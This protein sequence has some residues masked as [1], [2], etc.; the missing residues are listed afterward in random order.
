MSIQVSLLPQHFSC[1]VTVGSTL[2]AARYLGIPEDTSKLPLSGGIL[3]GPLNIDPTPTRVFSRIFQYEYDRTIA[4]SAL[5]TS[6]DGSVILIT[7]NSNQSFISTDYGQTFTYLT[8]PMIASPSGASM[9]SDGGVI[10]LIYPE[11]ARIFYSTNYGSTWSDSGVPEYY[12]SVSVSPDGSKIVG[13]TTSFAIGFNSSNGT[14]IFYHLG[15]YNISNIKWEQRVLSGLTQDVLILSNGGSLYI[16]VPPNLGTQ[17]DL[18]AD[19]ISYL[20]DF[21]TSNNGSVRL[22]WDPVSGGP[23]QISKDS[24]VTWSSLSGDPTK[25]WKKAVVSSTGKFQIAVQSNGDAYYSND[26]GDSWDS[27]GTTKNWIDINTTSDGKKSFFLA[28]D[29]VAGV[30]DGLFLSE[31]NVP[32]GVTT[33]AIS[34]TEFYNLPKASNT[35]YGV[36]KVDNN[37]VC[38]INGCLVGTPSFSLPTASSSTLGGVKVGTSLC[39]N[40][41]VL[42]SRVA[43]SSQLGS[44]KVGTSL[45]INNSIIDS[46]VASSSQLGAVKVGTSLCINNSVLDSRVAST[47]QLGAV[48][49]GN[50]L[51][52]DG[53]GFLSVAST[54]LSAYTS[55][56]NM[57]GVAS[58]GTSLNFSRGDHT[59]PSDTR[60]LSISGGSVTGVLAASAASFAAPITGTFGYFSGTLTAARIVGDLAAATFP[61]ASTIVPGVVKVDGTSI[62]INNGVI[63]GAPTFSLPIA[64]ASILGGV[65]I[66]SN[67]YFSVGGDGSFGIATAGY[68]TPGL[69]SNS[70]KVKLDNI[71]F[72]LGNPLMN[73]TAT[74]GSSTSYTRADHVHPS[75]TSRLPCSGGTLTGHLQGT[76]A[77]FTGGIMSQTNFT[78]PSMALSNCL[79]VTNGVSAGSFSGNG[80]SLTNL[81]AI[82]NCN[83]YIGCQAGLSSSGSHNTYLG[84]K[85]GQTVTGWCNVFIGSGTGNG[86]VSGCSNIAIGASTSGSLTSG[87]GNISMGASTTPSNTTGRDNI[88]IGN[89]ASFNNVSGSCNVALGINSLSL[90]TGSFNMGIGNH[91]MSTKTSGDCN[92][93]IGSQSLS[94]I[95]GTG[96]IAIG[97]RAGCA[98]T[99]GNNNIY[100]GHSWT[101]SQPH[102]T[103]TPCDSVVI[104]TNGKTY[105]T[106]DCNNTISTSGALCIYNNIYAPFNSVVAN[107]LC[108]SGTING[109][110]LCANSINAGGI[111]SR[112]SV[113]ACFS[114]CSDK[115][116]TKLVE[117]NKLLGDISRGIGVLRPYPGK[118]RGTPTRIAPALGVPN[119]Y[120]FSDYSPAANNYAVRII[121]GPNSTA[122]GSVQTLSDTTNNEI[123]SII[124]SRRLYGSGMLSLAND[125][126]FTEYFTLQNHS[127]FAGQGPATEIGSVLGTNGTRTYNGMSYRTPFYI[128][129]AGQQTVSGYVDGSY[130]RFS[131]P[132]C[133]IRS[134]TFGVTNLQPIW[135]V[136]DTGN[137]AIRKLQGFSNSTLLITST[138]AGSPARVSN[139]NGISGVGSIVSPKVI[140]MSSGGGYIFVWT[141][142]NNGVNTYAIRQVSVETGEIFATG[143]PTFTNVKAMVCS[144]IYLFVLN[145]NAVEVVSLSSKA[146][147]FRIGNVSQAGNVEGY[148]EN[149]RFNNPTDMIIDGNFLVITDAG[150]ND[151]KYVDVNTF[152]VRSLIITSYSEFQNTLS[153]S[154]SAAIGSFDSFTYNP[155]ALFSCNVI[156]CCVNSTEITG[157]VI[158][159][160]SCVTA[161]VVT[162]SNSVWGACCIGTSGNMCIFGQGILGSI[163]S[164]GDIIANGDI[165]AFATSD[166]RLKQNI[167]NIPDSLNKVMSLNG[168]SFDWCENVSTYIGRDIGV[169][170]QEVEDVMP[171]V[172]STRTNGYKAVRYEKLIPLL[173][174][175]IKELKIEIDD[176]KNK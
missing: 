12:N 79:Q 90:N 82:A 30:E 161:P 168:V 110:V 106:I 32:V 20:G 26:F 59:H 104:G 169:L 63:S 138:L 51:S 75:D 44:V 78:A 133:I 22:V 96:N 10:A 105:L 157:N 69:M 134:N 172:I 95:S 102:G 160:N 83:T 23:L 43:S 121:G 174:E 35:T 175:A 27:V 149:A 71:G 6:A 61:V 125:N 60:K 57:D 50:F 136:A 173:I 56:P 145:G 21:T 33:P 34:A 94:I 81:G 88:A 109:N 19:N 55:L 89:A 140:C 151:I 171:E 65:K 165:V 87:C 146:V 103:S 11:Q 162:A 176:L 144:D 31:I 39:I 14:Q 7:A 2:S 130:G 135:Y 36:V 98:L 24:G 170:A 77:T 150:N 93:A 64:S 91:A 155:G 3:T 80:S 117:A 132:S 86:G 126:F 97:V 111:V 154:T 52:I 53:N 116:T 123:K 66:P 92:I 143:F 72:S 58:A 107:N 156:T 122:P 167:T 164:C 85:T 100:I 84:S 15:F 4:W 129:S 73:G 114:V 28:A 166:C 113:I 37:T 74:P 67:G 38:I 147:V 1:D 29:T 9:S 152:Q 141:D 8:G 120:I 42:D 148:A 47:S 99:G 45:C 159:A 76:S 131:S 158:S 41:S 46:Q 142:F 13:T 18:L 118:L 54:P 108:S 5:T 163:C 40:N 101:G 49:V 17:W 112:G 16:S 153:L 25:N 48:K 128:Q 119:F 124:P 127:V 137:N 115:L 62:L 68:S 70:D 139:E